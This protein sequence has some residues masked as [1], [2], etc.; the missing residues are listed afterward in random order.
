MDQYK[1]DSKPLGKRTV[2][3][4]WVTK[5]AET[6][7]RGTTSQ[8]AEAA[9]GALAEGIHPDAVGQAIALAANE[10]TLRDNGRKPGQTS[11]HKGVGSCHGDSIGVH[12]CDSALAWQ[13]IAKAGG[14]RTTMSSLVLGAYQV[15]RDRGT[16]G[17]FFTWKPYPRPEHVE[18]VQ[19]IAPEKLLTELGG[20]VRENDQGRAAAIASRIDEHQAA[21]AFALLRGFA[22][23][24]DGALHAEKY[25][26]TTSFEYGDAR[27]GHRTRQLVA[28]ARVSASAYGF[29][30]P[31]ISEARSLLKV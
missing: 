16:S 22:V 25:Y 1:L 23:S 11:P 19:A 5:M 14:S 26:R 9:A 15:A 31:G 17:E 27:P 28:L 8:A 13:T 29:A 2:D 30:A 4:A 12:A 20:A 7:F 24:E 18:K 3:D 21:E 10:L 6:I